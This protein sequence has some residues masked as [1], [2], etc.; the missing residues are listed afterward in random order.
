MTRMLLCTAAAAALVGTLIAQT[1]DA[2]RGSAPRVRVMG[3]SVERAM[4]NTGENQFAGFEG[5]EIKL[6]IER[7]TGGLIG[8]DENNSAIT[9]LRDDQGTNLLSNR[10]GMSGLW[11]SE[12]APDG[13][14]IRLSIKG[15]VPATGLRKITASGDFSI[16]TASKFDTFEQKNVSFKDKTEFKTGPIEWTITKVAKPDWG[17]AAQQVTLMTRSDDGAIKQIRF[18]DENGNDLK[19]TAAGSSRM[20]FGTQS[21]VERYFQFP[22]AAQTATI[23]VEYWSDSRIERVPF[24]LTVSAGWD[25][26]NRQ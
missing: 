21:Q 26:G 18:L 5:T 19:A 12:V 1:G 2:Q 3:V 22:Q 6:V 16:R 8:V 13:K 14:R 11:V 7:P 9:A 15:G 23:A 25:D 24:N 10:V 17:D 20:S 4:E